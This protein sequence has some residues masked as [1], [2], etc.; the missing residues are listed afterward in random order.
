MFNT[1]D[2][3]NRPNPSNTLLGVDNRDLNKERD[4]KGSIFN[5]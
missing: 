3:S 1:L 4:K 5:L 2:F